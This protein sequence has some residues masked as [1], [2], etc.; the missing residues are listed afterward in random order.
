MSNREK[1][2]VELQA[3]LRNGAPKTLERLA[4]DLVGRLVGVR[5]SLAK[6]GFQHGADGGTTGRG[7]RHLRI[8]CKRYADST[9]LNER[10]LQGEID[11]ALRR[12]PSLEAWILVT[13][14]E[15]SESAQE[16]LNRKAHEVGVPIIVLD[17]SSTAASLPDL[18]AL[19][20]SADDLVQQHYGAKAGKAAR[21]LAP[22]SAEVVERITR[23]LSVWKIGYE[24]LRRVAAGRL[25]SIWTDEAESRVAMAQNVA[26]GASHSLV[27][28]SAVRQQLQAWWGKNDGRPAIVHGAE[29]VGKTWAAMQWVLAE[30]DDLPITLTA[31]SSAFHELSSFSVGGVLEFLGAS[32]FE[33]ARSHDRRYWR[34][35]VHALLQRPQEEG[36]TI[37]ILV[38]GINQEPSFNWQRLLQLFDGGDFRGRV[39]L[40]AT[41][42]T[43]YL[44]QRLNGMRGTSAGIQ[45]IVV[46][47][48]DLSPG[49]EFEQLLSMNGL[50]FEGIP[51]DLIP[52]ARVPRLF[53]LV[54]K[55][56]AHAATEGGATLSRLLW[57]HGRDE[58][59][60]RE[61]RAFSE[62]E[63]ERW[64]LGLAESHWS[65][66]QSGGSMPGKARTY[67]IDEL[68]QLV[69]RSSFD[70]ALNY[71]HLEEI[72]DG[73]WMEPV[74][75]RAGHFRPKE[76]TI[77]LALGAAVL[78]LL[79]DAERASGGNAELALA[80]WLDPLAGTSAAADILVA[81]MSI[82]V[83][84]QIP[85][86]SPVPGIVVTALLQ[87][88]NAQDGHREQTIAVAPAIFRALLFAA[89]QS[90]GRAQASA[91]HWALVALRSIQAE[92]RDAWAEICGVLVRWVAEVT[93]PSPAEVA[94][95][96]GA[97][98]SKAARLDERIG[99]HLA[100]T[101]LV[102]GVPI[103]LHELD[104]DDL[105]NHVPSLLIGKPLSLA[106]PVLAAAAVTMAIGSY[107]RL[108]QGLKWLVT[109]NPIDADEAVAAL[110]EISK[111]ALE[112]PVEG[113]VHPELPVRVASLLLW[114][115]G[116]ELHERR[117]NEMR[118]SF[119][120]GIDYEKDYLRNPTRSFFIPIEH[121][122][123]DLLWADDKI[124]PLQR[125][126]TAKFHLPDPHL[127]LPARFV[128]QVDKDV[129]DFSVE[130]LDAN[131]SYTRDDHELE[132]LQPLVARVAP[133]ALARLLRRWIGGLAG[134]TGE[135]RHWAALRA[136]RYLL[137]VR[138]TEVKSLQ[139]MRA[140]CP[141][142]ID[143]DERFLLMGLLQVELL[144]AS[145]DDQ[146]DALVA[147]QDT[148]LGLQLLDLFPPPQRNTIPKFIARWGLESQRAAEVLMA[149]LARRPVALERSLFESLLSHAV[150]QESPLR[151]LAFV[152]LG[153]TN[154]RWFGEALITHAWSAH[155]TY[156]DVEQEHGS[157]ALL[158]ANSHVDLDALGSLV[159]PWCLLREARQRG[160][161]PRLA[162]IAFALLDE[163]V[164][165]GGFEALHS[166]V[167]ISVDLERH[168]GSVSFE[169]PKRQQDDAQSFRDAFDSKLQ[170]RLRSDAAS[171]G[172]K[173][174][175]RA[176]D[177]GALM[178]TKLVDLEDARMLIEHCWAEVELW[179]DGCEERTPAFRNRVNSASGLFLA[180]CEALLGA[181]PD[182][183]APL[184]R[185][186]DQSLS[187]DF[188]G[189]GGVAEL[190][191]ILFRAPN[192][193]AVLSLRE[194]IYGLHRN[195]TDSSYLDIALCALLHGCADWLGDRIEA[196]R[197][198]QMPFRRKRAI[199]MSGLI[200]TGSEE[201][202][203]RP[204]GFAVGEWDWLR[205]RASFRV[206]RASYARHWWRV[207]LQSH[208]PE[209]AYA[210]WQVFLDCVDRMAHVWIRPDAKAHLSGD[211]G[212][213]RMK[214][215]NMELNWSSIERAM[216]EKETKGG[217]EMS[218]HL[219]SWDSPDDWFDIPQLAS[220]KHL[221]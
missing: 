101:R 20:A 135:R 78:G 156:N 65:A 138:P 98:K 127:V 190:R 90:A 172:K 126:R 15:A 215:L 175:R 52:L 203:E 117:A 161:T 30:L 180:L 155:A 54:L 157:L 189:L 141:D 130:E 85:P 35:R 166:G 197:D 3:E 185:A 149:Y 102:M 147:A 191:H 64:L 148:F 71:R 57:A 46:E 168:I 17:W 63:W 80:Q 108:W 58:L 76:S 73:T 218:R 136:C 16:T 40:L 170:S 151:T 201:P 112:V 67:S 145:L 179:L 48:Y 153:R 5:M 160:A 119:E 217:N 202:R 212:L 24:Q 204:T 25:S 86:T 128:R 134:R 198:S 209:A 206:N 11:D 45:R 165:A 121:R 75:G 154:A 195:L 51:R 186:L 131:E 104:R 193:P 133:S 44:D 214:L 177:A 9:P 181:M 68:D 205:R 32:I 2:L 10:E 56:S 152:C 37:L 14:R 106:M 97:G 70:P 21:A 113:G 43:H 26:G 162:R 139:R 216:S 211:A 109:L 140:N 116:V 31:P 39:R 129:G 19:C 163:A 173:F 137:L 100:G 27:T 176:T 92:N 110:V 150:G 144:H 88:Q 220:L 183:G 114:L 74:P 200:E 4:M 41:T 55:H 81:A 124:E 49:G 118:V 187:M 8:E 93:C 34:E 182:R 143:P 199:L 72:I 13:T 159:A 188:I 6:E 192:N 47:P 79:E 59:S 103:K 146:L 87:S 210:A 53:P 132:A 115:T 213:R 99:C 60:L 42:Q 50:N 111:A 96:D 33:L 66:I 12:N 62:S 125:L 38:D 120:G 18:A 107:N 28:R 1:H 208:D 83:A 84:K 23:E 22:L 207:Y 219:L 94:Q 95:K 142:P 105:K 77:Y 194:E 69:S 29:G 123:L 89:E 169:Q 7:G 158:A 171:M 122:H 174:L 82:L 91:R 36:P 164:N 178:L 221:S 184:W 61:G 167:D 196:D